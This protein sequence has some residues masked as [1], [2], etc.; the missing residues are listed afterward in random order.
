MA[1]RAI[2]TVI[3]VVIVFFR[4]SL[5]EGIVLIMGYEVEQ[6]TSLI[7]DCCRDFLEVN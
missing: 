5:K 6:Y 4:S 2:A 3:M 1:V 7:V